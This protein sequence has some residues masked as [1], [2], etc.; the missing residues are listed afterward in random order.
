MV[1]ENMIRLSSPRIFYVYTS[2]AGMYL[3]GLNWTLDLH[4]LAYSLTVPRGREQETSDN[5]HP[6]TAP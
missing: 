2:E 1:G 4:A 6:E 5:M 3:T